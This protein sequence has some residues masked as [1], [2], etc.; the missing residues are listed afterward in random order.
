MYSKNEG[1]LDSKQF[2]V[3]FKA[4]LLLLS[5][6]AHAQQ[7]ITVVV[8]C[9]LLEYLLYCCFVQKLWQKTFASCAGTVSP[10]TTEGPV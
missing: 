3:C 1:V 10:T 2:E 8:V 5:F 9:L 7:D 6:G 4:E